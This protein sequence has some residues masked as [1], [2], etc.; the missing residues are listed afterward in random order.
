MTIAATM[1]G[2]AGFL[3]DRGIPLKEF[4]DYM[5]E[6]FEGTLGSL[7]DRG[8]GEVMEHLLVLEVL[9]M[10]GE[11]VSEK[12]SAEK[13]EV[14]LTSLPPRA[15]LEKFGT[16][17]RELLRDF[18]VTQSEYE[19]FYAMFEPAAQAIGLSFRHRSIGGQ[20]SLVLERARQNSKT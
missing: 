15:L 5:G 12:L 4:V 9:P 13:A 14:T 7:E 19:S 20:E 3:K 11:V 2:I 10:G 17:P 18:G 16:T 8:A 1:A 6:K